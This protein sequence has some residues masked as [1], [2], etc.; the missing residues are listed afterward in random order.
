MLVPERVSKEIDLTFDEIN[1]LRDRRIP[2]HDRRMTGAEPAER[3]AER[4][5]DIE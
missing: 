5:V 3:V 4:N 2:V 1:I